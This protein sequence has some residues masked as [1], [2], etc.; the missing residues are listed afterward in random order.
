M[1][2]AASTPK[3]GKLSAVTE[4]NNQRSVSVP[5]RDPIKLTIRELSDTNMQPRHSLPER[6]VTESSIKR[7]PARDVKGRKEG[8]GDSPSH[9]E[10]GLPLYDMAEQINKEV[11]IFGQLLAVFML[12]PTCRVVSYITKFSKAYPVAKLL[13]SIVEQEYNKWFEGRVHERWKKE[14]SSGIERAGTHLSIDSLP[15]IRI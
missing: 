10:Q 6:G 8:R 12:F 1:S 11:R 3:H 15:L 4:P 9:Q 2:S 5:T 14:E 13:T 7:R